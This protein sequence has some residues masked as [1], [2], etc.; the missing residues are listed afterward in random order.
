[1]TLAAPAIR[2]A[3]R[4]QPQA[5]RAGKRLR[6]RPLELVYLLAIACAFTLGTG[7]QMVLGLLPAVAIIGRCWVRQHR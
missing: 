2:Q 6:L 1:M 7:P 3:D 5:A 4:R